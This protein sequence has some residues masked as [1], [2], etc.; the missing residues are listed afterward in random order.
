MQKSTLAKS[1]LSTL[2]EH[3]QQ[4]KQR[5]LKKVKHLKQTLPYSPS[6]Q[7]IQ[8]QRQKQQH[9]KPEDREMYQRKLTNQILKRQKDQQQ[10]HQK[11]VDADRKK[12]I[13]QQITAVAK[14]KHNLQKK[15][16][17]VNMTQEFVNG[18]MTMARQTDERKQFMNNI[19]NYIRNE[20]EE[21]DDERDL[22]Q[23]TVK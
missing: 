12:A 22:G 2:E 16:L 18:L 4:E 21:G 1:Y 14:D 5:E 15:E 3:Q 17:A 23:H 8:E 10:E 19:K 7:Q 13:A 20:S 11:L 9:Q 6:A